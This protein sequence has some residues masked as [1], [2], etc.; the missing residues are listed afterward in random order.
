M[1]SGA[2]KTDDQVEVL[3]ITRALDPEVGDAIWAA[4]E[5]LLPKRF[6]AHP[7]GCHRPRASDRACFNVMLVLALNEGRSMGG[8]TPPMNLR[9]SNRCCGCSL[10]SPSGTLRM[11]RCQSEGATAAH[12]VEA[13]HSG[14]HH[15]H[16]ANRGFSIVVVAARAGLPL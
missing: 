4:I 8:S 11:I 10:T 3:T 16:L 14:V 13:V 1:L 15:A 9:L 12:V 2:P 7:L 6:D 5:P